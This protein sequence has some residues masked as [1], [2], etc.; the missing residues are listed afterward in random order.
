MFIEQWILMLIILNILYFWHYSQTNEQFYYILKLIIDKAA[1]NLSLSFVK[2]CC[3]ISASATILASFSLIAH[4]FRFTV[5]RRASHTIVPRIIPAYLKIL[6][7]FISHANNPHN[8]FYR[9]WCSSKRGCG[10]RCWVE[11]FA[12]KLGRIPK[13]LWG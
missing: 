7:N 11:C 10:R 1:R 6:E 5:I 3:H 4:C 8:K 2:H 12:P 13:Y 9:A